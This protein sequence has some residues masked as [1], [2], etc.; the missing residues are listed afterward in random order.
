MPFAM[1]FAVHFAV[2]LA[3]FCLMITSAGWLHGD[4]RPINE[5]A[6]GVAESHGDAIVTLAVVMKIT[7][8][9]TGNPDQTKEQAAEVSGTIVNSK[10]WVATSY[11]NIQPQVN[12]GGLP[13]GIEAN[14]TTDIKE[15]K[16][17][18]ADGEESAAEVVLHDS[19]L[20][21]SIIRPLEAHESVAFVDF[22]GSADRP[23]PQVLDEIVLLGRQD[24]SFDRLIRVETGRLNAL[25]RRPRPM[26]VASVAAPGS[27]VFDRSGELLGLSALKSSEGQAPAPVIRP[28]TDVSKVLQAALAGSG[29]VGEEPGNSVAEGADTTPGLAETGRAILEKFQESVVSLQAITES[30]GRAREV[31]SIG[32]VIG[33][34][35]LVVTSRSGVGADLKEVKIILADGSE[36]PATVVLDDPDLDLAF[37]RAKQE[38]VE[39]QGLQFAPVPLGNEEGAKQVE[40]QVADPVII[41]TR[42]A[43]AFFRQAKLMVTYVDSVV[44]LPRR[45]YRTPE[46]EGGALAFNRSGELVGVYARRVSGE[47]TRHRMILPLSHIA[48]GAERARKAIAD[49]D[50]AGAESTDTVKE[51]AK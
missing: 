23:E 25:I 35:G 19:D 24:K 1:P 50:S 31:R 47:E 40:L 13:E 49:S 42:E 4:G 45:Y 51:E 48:D 26:F 17:V 16:I 30:G 44:D 37:V 7:L 6:R 29:V 28:I 32:A 21:V 34:D 14:I 5:V 9:V 11:S 10:G 33:A 18:W 38:E 15:I 12:P 36:V 41:L 2:P 46:K 20:D 39:A 43:P 8:T 3:V 27:P 22:L